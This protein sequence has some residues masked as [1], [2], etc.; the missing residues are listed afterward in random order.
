[1]FII[2]SLIF[3]PIFPF[4]QNHHTLKIKIRK[5]AQLKG[6]NASIYALAKGLE[7]GEFYSAGGDGW[8]VKWHVADPD[9]GQLVAK[10][11]SKVFSIAIFPERQ[12]LAAGN[13]EGGIHWIDLKGQKD[14]KNVAHHDRGIFAITPF[15]ENHALTG[16]GLGKLTKWDLNSLQTS[17]TLHL[18]NTS[19][20]AIAKTA[21]KIVIGASDNHIY[22]LNHELEIVHTIKDAHENS[23]FCVSIAPHDTNRIASG[24]RDAQLRHWSF[25]GSQLHQQNAHWFTIND[26][27]FSPNGTIFATA[28]R[29]KTIRLWKSDDYQL[30]KEINTIKN[31]GH[32]N[33]VNRL[34]WLDD[35]TLVSA[36]DDR[37]MIIWKIETSL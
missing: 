4:H 35:E 18:S 29:D 32:V 19:I 27:K 36:S 20:R 26:I 6:H 5:Q 34:L 33:S 15:D 7:T 24:G 16:G 25:D 37:T 28:S 2:K 8:I 31:A 10:T 12:L 11:E 22:I 1:M 3:A 23:V 30:I 13:M 14:I 21:D 17:E 9:L